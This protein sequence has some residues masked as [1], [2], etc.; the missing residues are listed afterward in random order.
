MAKKLKNLSS[1]DNF[2]F[3][4]LRVS[5][6]AKEFQISRVRL[7]SGAYSLRPGKNKTQIS[8]SVQISDL[9]IYHPTYS[10][11]HDDHLAEN[12]SFPA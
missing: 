4:I 11:A 2:S 3:G 10:C 8:K 5:F 7:V 1:S 9:Q 6:L 12:L